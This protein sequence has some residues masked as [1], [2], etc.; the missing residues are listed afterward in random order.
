MTTTFGATPGHIKLFTS[1]SLTELSA[2]QIFQAA[3][4]NDKTGGV[5]VIA[6]W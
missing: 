5:H 3:L 4:V 1:S 6:R 2:S